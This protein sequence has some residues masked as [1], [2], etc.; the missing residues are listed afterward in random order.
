M[1]PKTKNSLNECESKMTT[2]SGRQ[3]SAPT[4][5]KYL[6][7]EVPEELFKQAKIQAL[8][9]GLTW[10]KYVCRVL[11]LAIKQPDPQHRKTQA[12]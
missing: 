11:E 1:P 12:P 10:T 8:Q 4:K 7:I 3:A 9:S 5:T 2:N 6:H